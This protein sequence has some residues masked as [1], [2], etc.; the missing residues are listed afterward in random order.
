M[1]K[2]QNISSC[3]VLYKQSKEMLENFLSSYTHSIRYYE[4]ILTKLS[5]LSY[6]LLIMI[7][8]IQLIMI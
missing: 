5:H 4:K 3:V 6:M 7:L 1:K 8:K 2:V